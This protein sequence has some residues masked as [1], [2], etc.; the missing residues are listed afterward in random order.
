MSWVALKSLAERRIRAVLTALAVVLGV[1]MIAGSLHPHR[2]HRSMPSPPSSAARTQA[3][4]W[5]CAA[6]PSSHD[7]TTRAPRPFPRAPAPADRGPCRASPRPP[8]AWSTSPAPRN[9]AKP[10]A[11]DGKVITGAP[12]FGFGVDPPSRAS[13]LSRSTEGSL[14]RGPGPGR[15][16]RRAPPSDHGFAVGDTDRRAVDGPDPH[17]HGHRAGPLRRRRLH[18]RRDD[19]RVRRPDRSR[20]C[21]ARPAS[22]P[23]QVAAAARRHRGASS[24]ASIAPLLPADRPGPQTGDE[25]AQADKDDV[26]ATISFIR[27][28]LLAFG[29][30]ALFVGAFVIFN[31]LSITV[32]QR[33]RELATLRTLGA[34]RRQVMRAVIAEAG[35]HRP[36]RPRSSGLGPAS[37]WPRA[38][39]PLFRASAPTCPRRHGLRDPHHRRVAAGRH[40]RHRGRRR[41]AGRSARPGSPPIAAVR[42]G[43]ELPAH[44]ARRRAPV[45]ACR[46][47]HRRRA[48][49]S[50]PRCWRTG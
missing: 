42:E 22:T 12:S 38:S 46:H 15:H 25:Q 20:R 13:T 2:H 11:G 34:S 1:A 23:I 31:T 40:P 33:S 21:S 44:A 7:A 16:R 41:A 3:P 48:R 17:L 36:R 27:G 24:T 32:A 37:G 45:A 6:R 18:R 43:A 19:R 29:G 30:I 49:C 4:T 10:S 14:G 28:F 8:A 47:R 50:P 35:S 9:N 26:A 39:T 5:S